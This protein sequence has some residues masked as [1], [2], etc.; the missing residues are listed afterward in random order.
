ME[1]CKVET[2][3]CKAERL[4]ENLGAFIRVGNREG[5]KPETI[6]AEVQHDINQHVM[7]V[8]YWQAHCHDYWRKEREREGIVIKKRR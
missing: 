8:L 7:G 5:R 2:E 6:L 3:R 1:R 4:L